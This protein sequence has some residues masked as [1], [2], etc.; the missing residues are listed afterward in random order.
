[1]KIRLL[2]L[3]VLP[4]LAGCLSPAPKAPTNWTI[5]FE[6]AAPCAKLAPL[7]GSVRIS[8]VDVRAP[9]SGQ[10]LAVLRPDG[11]VAF[12]AFNVFA[13]SPSQLLSG[14]A[15]D[16]VRASG[17]FDDVLPIGTVAKTQYAME[18]VVTQLALDCRGEG[19]R[20]ARVACTL[21][22]LR[23][24]VALAGVCGAGAEETSAG[25]Y[26]AAFSTAFARAMADALGKL[27]VP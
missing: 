10:R 3:A 11:T 16:V 20:T 12:D 21:L 1:M 25:D 24:R 15:V 18:I 8:S 14:A 27:R 23:D 19:A 26:S 2:P 17:R 4:V 13:S 7:G 22:L 6:R 9:Y 5:D